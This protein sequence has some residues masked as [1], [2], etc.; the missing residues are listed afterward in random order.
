MG[1]FV[2]IT[3][4]FTGSINANTAATVINLP[5]GWWPEKNTAIAAWPSDIDTQARG[6]VRS[7][8]GEVVIKP[9]TALSNKEINFT[10]WFKLP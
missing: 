5:S 3:A 2:L 6:W 1:K 10:G 7:S 9:T 4:S 8:S